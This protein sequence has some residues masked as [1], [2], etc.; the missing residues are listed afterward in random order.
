MTLK[1]F[2][3]VKLSDSSTSRLQDN[4]QTTFESLTKVSLLD[5]ILIKDLALTASSTNEIE[6]KL[7]RNPIGWI[8]VRQGAQANIWDL[9]DANK[10]PSKSLS[11]ACSADVTID[12][13]VF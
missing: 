12:L 5:G 9:Q 8:V 2:K 4:C 1:S 11:L 6:H 10:S 13:W 3:K 7:D